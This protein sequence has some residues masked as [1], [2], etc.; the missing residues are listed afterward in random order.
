MWT[1]L[2]LDPKSLSEARLLLHWAS[3]LL[4]RAGAKLA[5]AKSDDSHTSLHWERGLGAIVGEALDGKGTRVGLR[6]LDLSVL[7][8]RGGERLGSLELEKKTLKDALGE[9][10]TLL[11]AALGRDI[12]EFELPEYEMPDHPVERGAPFDRSGQNEALAELERWIKNAH[13]VLEQVR[14]GN[15]QASPVRLW[16][17]HFDMAT[18]I[19][20]APNTDPEKAKS[21]N[22]GF[23][24]GDASY[25]EPYV[26]VSPWP[27]PQNRKEAPPLAHGHWHDEG[28]F[29]AIL[30]GS[31]VIAR[32]V[33]GQ[34]KRV[35]AFLEEANDLSRTMLGLP[36]GRG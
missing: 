16:P 28:Y 33:D 20:V 14:R 22:L 5:P 3:Q 27:Y 19:T 4:G 23:S 9:F 29:A 21:V 31:E 26:Y 12:G 13:D 34:A 15:D 17:H 11:K 18:L 1:T 7:V 10:G 8:L 32:G 35:E 24:F 6:A 30:T 25:A 36:Q 2:K